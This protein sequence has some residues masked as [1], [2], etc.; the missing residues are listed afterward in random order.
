MLKKIIAVSGKPGLFRYI[1]RGN[2]SLIVE[3]LDDTKKRQTIFASQKAV[4]L[5]DISI[6]TDDGKE[7]PL[8]TVME[9]IKAAYEGKA[10]PLHPKKAADSEITAFFLKALPDYDT[11]RVKLSDMR[12]VLQWYNLLIGAGFTQFT[13]QEPAAET[14]ENG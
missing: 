11:D 14:P 5:S 1:A 12:K 4:A 6:Y 8:Y 3:A 9:N 7:K 10:V 2:N 13:P